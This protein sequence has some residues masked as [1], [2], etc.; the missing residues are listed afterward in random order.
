MHSRPDQKQIFPG[1]MRGL[2]ILCPMLSEEWETGKW[3]MARFWL[4]CGVLEKCPWVGESL[5]RSAKQQGI[6]KVK[7]EDRLQS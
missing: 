2:F 7:Q 4:S 3:G 5:P 1:S 6:W